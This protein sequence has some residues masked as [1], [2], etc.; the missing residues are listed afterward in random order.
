MTP[1]NGNN[2]EPVKAESVTVRYSDGT[3]RIFSNF[4]LTACNSEMKEVTVEGLPVVGMG[5]D[6]EQV[7]HVALPQWAN[8]ILAEKAVENVTRFVE[9]I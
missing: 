3:A 9:S 2:P 6:I 1:K 4:I 5:L 8:M 7:S